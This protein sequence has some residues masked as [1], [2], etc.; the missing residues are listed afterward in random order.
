MDKWRLGEKMSLEEAGMILDELFSG[1]K[2]RI[3]YSG[4]TKIN[5]TLVRLF[6]SFKSSTSSNFIINF[7]HCWTADP[8]VLISFEFFK[9]SVVTHQILLEEGTLY[10]Y[11]G[12]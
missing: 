1:A 8:G 7:T 5:P 11:D 4:D 12:K 3:K 2:K 10:I 9:N 6:N